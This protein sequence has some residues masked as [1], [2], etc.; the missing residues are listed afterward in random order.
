MREGEGE[1]GGGGQLKTAL[2]TI[3]IDGGSV[4]GPEHSWA[5]WHER[6]WSLS[7][8]AADLD[9]A[10]HSLAWDPQ[11]V[12]SSEF[13]FPHLLNGDHHILCNPE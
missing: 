1:A 10:G 13:Y 2:Q 12:T 7:N 6:R 3:P 5:A 11:K 9:P 8:P 4:K